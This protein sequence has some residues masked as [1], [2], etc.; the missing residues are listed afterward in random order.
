M[1]LVLV[2]LLLLLL[3]LLLQYTLYGPIVRVVSRRFLQVE[4][5]EIITELVDFPSPSPFS[6]SNLLPPRFPAVRCERLDLGPWEGL[7]WCAAVADVVKMRFVSKNLQCPRP[8]YQRCFQTHSPTRPQLKFV[9]NSRPPNFRRDKLSHNR[10]RKRREEHQTDK[11]LTLSSIQV[12]PPHLLIQPTRAF[13]ISSP[14][15]LRPRPLS[16]FSIR[17]LSTSLTSGQKQK[18]QARWC[19]FATLPTTLPHLLQPGPRP[20]LCFVGRV[21]SPLPRTAKRP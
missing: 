10:S 15:A 19:V 16:P 9:L 8:G 7:F 13:P 18:N 6:P 4:G 17:I 20:R 14:S 21:V 5:A 11:T 3:L 12:N 2:L 1:V